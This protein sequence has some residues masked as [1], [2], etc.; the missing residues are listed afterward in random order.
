ML[1]LVKQASLAWR[2]LGIWV[3]KISSKTHLIF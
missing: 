1:A 2:Y 3:Q